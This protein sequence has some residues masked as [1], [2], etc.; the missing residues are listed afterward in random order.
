MRKNTPLRT[1]NHVRKALTDKIEHI[2]TH[3]EEASEKGK[4]GRK[5]FEQGYS[6]YMMENKINR[7]IQ[8]TARIKSSQ[9]KLEEVL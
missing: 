5:L 1:G 2:R 6:W 7:L 8:R 4:K 9:H 3:P